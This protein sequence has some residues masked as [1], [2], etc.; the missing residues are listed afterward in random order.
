MKK[1]QDLPIGKKCGLIV[2]ASIVAVSLALIVYNAISFNK[3]VN[4]EFKERIVDLGEN[5][6]DVI[7]GPLSVALSFG[8]E[9]TPEIISTL[10]MPLDA[11]IARK[12][13]VYVFLIHNGKVVTQ[14]NR[15]GD[16]DFLLPEG[17][18]TGKLFGKYSEREV[19]TKEGAGYEI[20]IPVKQAANKSN[21]DGGNVSSD[22][23]GSA[24]ALGEVALGFDKST[25]NKTIRRALLFSIF[26]TIVV[27]LILTFIVMLIISRMIVKPIQETLEMAE[28]IA[29][30]NL[31]VHELEIKTEDEV[32]T[33]GKSLNRMRN[34][35]RETIG[36]VKESAGEVAIASDD[37]FNLTNSSS[38]GAE[39][40]TSQIT[41]VVTAVGEMS[42]TVLEVA[43]NSAD[44]SGSAS[45]AKESAVAG[46]KVV[47]SSLESMIRIANSVEISAKTIKELGKTSTHIGE[48]VAVID[49]IADQTNLLALN[50]AIE[51]ARAGEQGM[52]FAVVSNEVKKLAERTTQATK[53]IADRISKIQKDTL[54]AV[55]AMDEW[56]KEVKEGVEFSSSAGE[57]LKQIVS[58]VQNVTDMIAQIATAT[59]E[60]SAATEEISSNIEDIAR[61]SRDTASGATQ[62]SGSAKHLKEQANNLHSLVEQFKL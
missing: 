61:V 59:E 22:K 3:G 36:K 18:E 11:M 15:F 14:A 55:S 40:Q 45:R 27:A 34:N 48:I 52:G 31:S 49:D 21:P 8:D 6:S 17:R 30:G 57:S 60:Q 2:L 28:N 58:L 4:R 1:L 24:S 50:A 32:G 19:S 25:V 33:L 47:Q 51:A 23:A 38:S 7:A 20:R 44:A 10:N 41:H 37:I 16:K 26:I 13:I 9:F 12:D 46:S 54:D 62:A 42:S 39:K 53:E 35:L 56:N 43:K 5:L 29:E